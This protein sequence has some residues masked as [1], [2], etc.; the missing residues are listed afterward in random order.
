[1]TYAIPLI[2]FLIG[3]APGFT[4]ARAGHAWVVAIFALGGAGA[5]FWAVMA[6]RSQAQGWDAIG[7][8]VFA[9]MMIAPVVLGLVLGGLGGLV[10]RTRSGQGTTHD[11]NTP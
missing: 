7:Y 10:V 9:L 5:G 1:M 3:L 6:G 2:G 8:G 4:L 11:G